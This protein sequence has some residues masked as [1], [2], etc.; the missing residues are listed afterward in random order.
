MSDLGLGNIIT[1]PQQRDAIHIAVAPVTAAE[2][3]S[4]GEDIGFIQ[5]GDNE[6]VGACRRGATRYA[7]GIV[8]PF[9]KAP[10]LKGEQFWMFLYPGSITS[11]RHDW[12]HPAFAEPKEKV[13]SERWLAD[14]A[15]AIG[16]S[17]RGL[18]DAVPSWHNV[19]GGG[20]GAERLEGVEGFDIPAA[21]WTHYEIATGRSVPAENRGE[22]FS[23]S[24]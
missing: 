21:F 8:D 12:T 11:L 1:T 2:D 15:Q 16:V 3:L 24:C 10:V 5:P 4:V 7:I 9:L 14:F 20:V 17:Y 23:C 6:N 19:G 22:F 13:V 18:I